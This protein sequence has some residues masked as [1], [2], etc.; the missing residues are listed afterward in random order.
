MAIGLGV[1]PQADAATY[2]NLIN[3][4]S[5]GTSASGIEAANP[6][7]VPP[8]WSVLLPAAAAPDPNTGFGGNLLR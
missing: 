1:N 2:L 4:L 7:P 5:S 3:S 8:G 6:G